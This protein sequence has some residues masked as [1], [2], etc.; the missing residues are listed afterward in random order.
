MV[1][2]TSKFGWNIDQQTGQRLPGLNSKPDHI[3]LVVEGSLKRLRTDRMSENYVRKARFWKASSP[4]A[5]W[6][7]ME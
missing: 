4:G 1:R 3:K 6:K 5:E 2:I 7:E